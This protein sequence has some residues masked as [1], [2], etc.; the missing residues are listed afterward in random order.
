MKKQWLMFV[1]LSVIFGVGGVQAADHSAIL[2]DLQ[3][4]YPG[5]YANGVLLV[6]DSEQRMYWYRG[7]ELMRTYVISTAAKGLGSRSGSHK[8]PS[9]AHRISTK[10]GS[11]AKRGA[12]FEKLRN[13]GR[14]A[15][16]HTSPAPGVTALILTRIL[17]LDGLEP[18]NN[19]GGNVDTFNRAIYFH[20]TNK[21]GNLGRRASHGCIRMNNDEIIKLFSQ[22][23]VDTLVYIQP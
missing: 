21:E 17:R 6:D 18:G 11:T 7:A 2:S 16:I 1:L 19:K 4:K 9:G 13:T 22:I 20:G 3:A 12:V 10:V 15:T 14:I 8:T 23:P 5:Y